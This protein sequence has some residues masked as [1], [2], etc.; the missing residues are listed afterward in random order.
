MND[1][2]V[3]LTEDEAWKIWQECGKLAGVDYYEYAMKIIHAYEMLSKSHDHSIVVDWSNVKPEA[4]KSDPLYQMGYEAAMA[5]QKPMAWGV[6]STDDFL[7]FQN[8]SQA[9]HYATEWGFDVTP[10]AATIRDLK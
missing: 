3:I 8:E 7:I 10:L 9:Q 4:I 1:T 2:K 6:Q 5:E